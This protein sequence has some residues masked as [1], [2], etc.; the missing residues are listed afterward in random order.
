MTVLFKGG[1]S[2]SLRHAFVKLENGPI[3]VLEQAGQH[4]SSGLLT[5]SDRIRSLGTETSGA[6]CR[7]TGQLQ[8]D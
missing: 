3:R 1:R 5:I 7:G 2:V 8:L 4:L 6:T